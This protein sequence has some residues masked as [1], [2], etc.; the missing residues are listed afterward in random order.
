MCDGVGHQ[1]AKVN[2]EER[3]SD[4]IFFHCSAPCLFFSLADQRSILGLGPLGLFIESLVEFHLL[5]GETW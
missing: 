2:R 5:S 4:Y 1:Y 3:M